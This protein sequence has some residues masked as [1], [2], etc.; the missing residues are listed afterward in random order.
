[1]ATAPYSSGLV[2]LGAML[3]AQVLVLAR[4]PFWMACLLPLPFQGGRSGLSELEREAGWVELFDGQSLAG[5]HTFGEQGVRSGGWEVVDGCLHLP[6][7]AAGG[8]LVTNGEFR[9]FELELEWKIAP[10]AN[11]GIKYRVP[12]PAGA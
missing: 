6:A 2:P 5:W 9:D 11:S 8:D 10:G 4:T 7:G 12:E 3:P 1:M